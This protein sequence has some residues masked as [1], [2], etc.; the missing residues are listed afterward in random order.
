M[1][2]LPDHPVIRNMEATGFPDG[3]E[4]DYPRC[5]MCGKETDNVY[6]INDTGDIIG[7]PEC[8]HTKDAWEVSECFPE[9]T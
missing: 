6:V 4:P 1:N 7:C 9:R 2:D 3:K 5:P 8:I